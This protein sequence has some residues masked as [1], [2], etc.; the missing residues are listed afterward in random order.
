MKSEKR[1]RTIKRELVEQVLAPFL[2]ATGQIK[3]N[4]IA[5]LEN[6]PLDLGL[7]IYEEKE[8]EVESGVLLRIN[9]K[10]V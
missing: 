1:F 8:T 4:E 9:G 10:K 2:L 7:Y 5:V 6:C 3:L